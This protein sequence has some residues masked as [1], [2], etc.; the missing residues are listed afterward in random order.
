MRSNGPRRAKQQRGQEREEVEKAGG[1]SSRVG[2][3]NLNFDKFESKEEQM[4]KEDCLCGR[5]RR[6][7]RLENRSG[8]ISNSSTYTKTIKALFYLYRKKGVKPVFFERTRKRTMKRFRWTLIVLPK[9]EQ[10]VE[11]SVESVR[12]ESHSNCRTKERTR[13]K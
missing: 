11:Q 4:I 12:T 3:C 7:D 6:G 13:S 5:R 10:S 1:C 9:R 2:I 8:T